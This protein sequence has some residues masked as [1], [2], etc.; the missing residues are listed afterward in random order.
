MIQAVVVVLLE[1]ELRGEH[2]VHP[3]RDLLDVQILALA[4]D[5]VHEHGAYG[6]LPAEEADALGDDC[7]D[8]VGLALLV[9]LKVHVR[10]HLGGVFEAQI[11]V[12]VAEKVLAGRVADALV[13]ALHADLLRHHVDDEVGG[14][15]V[16]LVVPPLEHV[17]VVQV[18][19][20]HGAVVVVYLVALRVHLELADQVGQLAE[21]A[22]GEDVGGVGVQHRDLV[23]GDLSHLA[24]EVAVLYREEAGVVPRAGDLPADNRA[25][26][27]HGE[28]E[29]DDVKRHG[30]ALPRR[31]HPLARARGLRPAEQQRAR[32]ENGAEQDDEHVKVARMDVY[33]RKLEIEIQKAEYGGHHEGDEQALSPREDLA[34]LARLLL[35]FGSI[36][37]LA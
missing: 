1:Y 16:A 30:G 32:A 33:G 8:P 19:D 15:A 13:E 14:D 37:V 36:A 11:A 23:E 20:A 28:A 10:E 29:A 26:Y 24:G 34:R 2:A 31:R 17:A 22:R 35:T 12:D 9:H 5:G 4:R 25:D 27:G 7:G 21:A 3:H 18:S 6:V